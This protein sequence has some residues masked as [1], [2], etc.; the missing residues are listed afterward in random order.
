VFN[1][2][3]WRKT[4]LTINIISVLIYIHKILIKISIRFKI[5]V[6]DIVIVCLFFVFGKIPFDSIQN[7]LIKKI[8]RQ[9]TS[10]TGGI[11]YIHYGVRKIFSTYFPIF[12]I[13]NFK[14][15]LINYIFCYLICFIGSTLFNKTKLKFLFL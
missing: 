14:S 7:S 4:S 11:Y 1:K 15:C 6:V 3:K 5:L 8:I 2:N 13:G 9:L 10:Y 12:N